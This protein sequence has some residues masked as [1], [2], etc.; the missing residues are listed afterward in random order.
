M[1]ADIADK[2]KMLRGKRG[3]TQ[4]E[5]AKRLEITHLWINAWNMNFSFGS[6]FGKNTALYEQFFG[7]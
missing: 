7:F 5:L 4:T 2:R 6:V 3:F 1:T